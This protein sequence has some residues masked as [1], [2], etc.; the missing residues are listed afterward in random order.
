MK[1]GCE[2]CEKLPEGILCDICELG[3]LEHTAEA[4]IRDYIEKVNKILEKFKEKQNEFSSSNP[5]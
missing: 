4:A 5:S 1:N 3:L 2:Q